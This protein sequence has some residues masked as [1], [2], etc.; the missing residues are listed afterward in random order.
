MIYGEERHDEFGGA[1][2]HAD[3]LDGDAQRETRELSRGG[4]NTSTLLHE[5]EEISVGLVVVMHDVFVPGLLDEDFGAKAGAGSGGWL[6]CVQCVF[7][8]SVRFRSL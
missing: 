7:T 5:E 3:G 8:L 6:T 4:G 2:P 1:N